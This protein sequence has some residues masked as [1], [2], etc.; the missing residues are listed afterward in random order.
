LG[1]K[2]F[3]VEKEKEWQGPF[4]FVQGADCQPGLTDRWTG[5]Y[6]KA[7]N[8]DTPMKYGEILL[9]CFRIRIC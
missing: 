1:K 9:F 2:F 7:C 8:P 6:R 5:T 4:F 3:F